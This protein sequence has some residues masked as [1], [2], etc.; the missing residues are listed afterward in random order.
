MKR[1]D[2][3]GRERRALTSDHGIDLAAPFP[4]CRAA[5]AEAPNVIPAGIVTAT[6][7][8]PPSISTK[9]C[10][11]TVTSPRR[12]F[13]QRRIV[14]GEALVP[15]DE[16]NREHCVALREHVLVLKREFVGGGGVGASHPDS[17]PEALG[18]DLR[19][20]PRKDRSAERGGREFGGAT[21]D[22]E[23]R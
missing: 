13:S 3:G 18:A 19:L 14:L 5:A 4:G 15:L 9:P 6:A 11:S 23:R 21:G 2:P 20:E 12:A 10:A 16:T 17:D 7:I 8:A 22:V 1:G